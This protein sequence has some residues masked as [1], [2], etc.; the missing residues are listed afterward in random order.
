MMFPDQA[1]EE[2]KV[3]A[4]SA[5]ALLKEADS[6]VGATRAAALV[7]LEVLLTTIPR[8][9]KVLRVDASLAS[10]DGKSELWIDVGTCHI[11]GKNIRSKE[12]AF[13]VQEQTSRSTGDSPL[14]PAEHLPSTPAVGERVKTKRLKYQPL[15]RQAGVQRLRL[16]RTHGPVFR[17]CI[18]SHTGEF[19]P[20]A[21]E[22]IEFLATQ[23]PRHT[24]KFLRDDGVSSSRATTL[25]RT[26]LKD[27]IATVIVQGYGNMLRAVG[28]SLAFTD[29]R[30][31]T[32][33]A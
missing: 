6:L 21:F 18:V 5:D 16:H 4:A 14:L 19:S 3:I 8:K 32:G 12:L 25:F 30:A 24:R 17:A 9:T 28:F 7:K 22:T 10:A 13:L 15:L 26:T 31:H 23:V 29:A 33:D 2:L 20:D 1:T 11:S 27:C